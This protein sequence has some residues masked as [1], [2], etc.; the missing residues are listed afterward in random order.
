MK[1]LVSAG[2]IAG[3]LVTT[4]A[5]L[6]LRDRHDM[7]DTT[8]NG[9][10]DLFA[11]KDQETNISEADYYR[12]VTRV[13]KDR[14]VE[15]ITDDQKLLSGSVRGMI[16]GLGDID[17]QYYNANQFGALKRVRSGTYHGVN[18][19]FDYKPIKSDLKTQNDAAL[20]FPRLTVVSVAPGS[21]ADKAGVKPGD[22][23]TELDG[24][25]IPNPEDYIRYRR[26]Q[27]D[28]A[29]KKIDFKTINDMRKELN[30]KTAKSMSAVHAMEKL[31]TGTTGTVHVSFDRAGSPV[32]ATLT[33]G[34]Y[35]FPAFKSSNGAFTL[36]FTSGAQA[37]LKAF[38]EGK[39]E[40][41]LDLRNNVMGDFETMRQCLAV[42][43]PAATY[44][45]FES[46]NTQTPLLLKTESGNEK[47]PK[48]KL[49]V[50]QSTRD[51]AEI[52]ALA[53][54]G[55]GFA[56]LSGSEM[57]NKHKL[58]DIGQLPDGSGYTLVTGEFKPGV[59]PAKN[60]KVA[61]NESEK[62]KEVS[63]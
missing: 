18:A 12:E 52:F 9:L 57:G 39:S 6:K 63:K 4:I 1:S 49:L 25:L 54:S 59:P 5:G 56:T 15:P 33:K 28:F 37:A 41:T 53:L 44:G 38:V 35:E 58:R 10:Y 45:Y 47:R 40:V 29:D 51:A 48:I 2:I 27:L 60:A 14:Y 7:P 19:W 21:A 23:V 11:S 46:Q 16:A 61:L 55:K 13:L 22:V 36:V 24:K 62:K 26:A 42:V 50:D 8:A 17:S 31:T 43:A 20:A 32:E 3:L 30:A 34:T